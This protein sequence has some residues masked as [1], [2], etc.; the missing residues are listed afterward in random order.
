MDVDDQPG[1]QL[2]SKWLKTKALLEHP[3]IAGHIPPSKLFGSSRLRR[4]LD[5]Y[6]TVVVKPVRGAG[7]NGVIKIARENGAYSYAYRSQRQ[8]FSHFSDLLDAVNRVRK[9]KAYLIQQGIDLA[10]IRGR[11]IDYRVKYVK[12]GGQWK[13]RSMVGRVARRGY[14][15]TNLCRGGSLLSA[16]EGLRQSLS[17]DVVE[18]KK[19]EMRELTRTATSLL[20]RRFP[21]VSRLG[22]DY[23]ID[24]NGQIWI[25]EV[26]TRPQ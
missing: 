15:V 19:Q 24:R 9:G 20:E 8:I 21:G 14:F 26:N 7:G 23:G 10:Q 22:Y 16:A 1:R 3:D 4:M 12:S 5:R 13:F 11:P 25:L 2:A 18:A 6:G 17:P